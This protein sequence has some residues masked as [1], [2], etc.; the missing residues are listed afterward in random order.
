MNE[1]SDP[2]S[3][4]L[5]VDDTPANLHLL[6]D[7]LSAHGFNISVAEDGESALEQLAFI[8]PDL[9]LLD[10]MMPH[11]DGFETCR[12]L[13]QRPD[14]QNTPVIFM[15]ALT[16]TVDKVKGFSLGA[17]D[18]I[19]KPFQQ[20]EVLVRIN[21]H[22]ALERLKSRLRENESRLSGIIES[23]MDAIVT[24]DFDGTIILFNR[25]AERIFRCAAS[26][27]LGT[28]CKRFLAENLFRRLRAYMDGEEKT[29]VWI[30]PGHSAVRVDGEVFPVE[31]S[32]SHAVA[33]GQ[34]LYTLILRDNQ[35]RQRAEAERQKLHGLN[36]YLREE[37]RSSQGAN[38]LIGQSPAWNRVIEQI[39]QVAETDAGVLILGETGTGKE[40]VTRAIHGRSRRRDKLLVKLNCAALPKELV[41]SELFGH[42]SGAFTGA[43]ARKLGRFELAD[44]GTLFLD[45]VGELPLDLQA[46]LLRVLQEREFERVGG[47]ETLR[48]DVRVV[49]ASNR[50][51]GACVRE[52]SFRPD[53]YYRLN[54]FPI[55]LPP[56]RERLEDLPLL[57]RYFVQLYGDKYGRRIDSVSAETLS[58]LSA[59]NWPGNI[60][61]LQHVVER[62]VILSRDSYL[63][64]DPSFLGQETLES[65]LA[66]TSDSLEHSERARI[67]RVLEAV[68]WRVS[69][70]GGAAERLGL[71]PTTLEYRM[72]KHGLIRPR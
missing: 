37:L 6:F 69:G 55:S 8:R 47:T 49:A 72:K 4:I 51:L 24:I 35:E 56:L 15:S 40:G 64:F 70:R 67:L 5:V 44:G 17:V 54:V 10:A 39:D 9:I 52:G 21:S 50:D 61:E 42:E 46:K 43:V 62:A 65:T 48:V 19:T 53:L 1:P 66:Y 25:A 57:I 59:H 33:N 22:L 26:A 63:T 7:L 41:E 18:Y 2:K 58:A 45:E 32:F 38:E 28:P 3:L 34:N 29:P 23:A 13:K 14:T 60:R 27:A 68:K 16:D 71:K 11:L 36:L 12:R 30:S 31:A 20:E